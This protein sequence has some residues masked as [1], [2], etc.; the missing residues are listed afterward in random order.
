MSR[1]DG[2]RVWHA[3]REMAH[4]V[5]R[6]AKSFPRSAP[7]GLRSQLSS[8]AYSV[9]RNIAEGVG[10]GTNGEK[11]Q[12][13]R[14][15]RGSLEEAQSDLRLS[16]DEGLIDRKTFYRLWNRTVVINRMLTALIVKMERS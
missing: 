4:D 15:A 2:L 6:V 13:F 3:A 7:S 9:C 14:L 11:V 1:A 8:A 16:A 5:N 12:F 10:R